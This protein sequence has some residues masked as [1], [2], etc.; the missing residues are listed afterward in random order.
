MFAVSD[1]YNFLANTFSKS[2]RSKF[3]NMCS[4]SRNTIMYVCICFYTYLFKFV[5]RVKA[6]VHF[7]Y[8]KN[9]VL[10]KVMWYIFVNGIFVRIISQPLYSTWYKYT[11]QNCNFL[12]MIDRQTDR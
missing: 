8:Y 7:I 3:T 4:I 6:P 9:L 5:E 11:T 12:F 2:L 1:L 10:F